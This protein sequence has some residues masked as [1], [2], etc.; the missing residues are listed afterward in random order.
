MIKPVL[1]SVTTML[2][3][4][5]LC[6]LEACNTNSAST[7]PVNAALNLSD[8]VEACLYLKNGDL[9][10]RSDEDIVGISLRNMNDSDKSYSHS[11]LAFFE[12]SAWYIYNMMAGEENPS[13]E[14]RRDPLS[15]FI[16]KKRKSGYGIYRYKLEP[17]M[18][19]SMHTLVKHQYSSKLKFDS[20]FNLNDDETM[21]CSEM[22]SKDLLHASESKIIIPT[23]KKAN[24][25]FKAK[26]GGRQP[27]RNVEYIAIDN[28]YLNGWCMLVF[29][30]QY[31]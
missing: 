31:K 19:D 29:R 2:T 3:W 6:S 18:I 20:S 11:G 14:M 16:D 27:K 25:S 23:T 9:V 12:D 24:F 1:T 21:Y 13:M 28:L 26:D 17:A 10:V 30:K 5:L 8:S 15:F 4:L 22:I 7:T